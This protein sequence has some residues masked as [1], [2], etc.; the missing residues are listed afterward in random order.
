MHSAAHIY[1][2]KFFKNLWYVD[3]NFSENLS[4]FSLFH[5]IIEASE[6]K[7]IVQPVDYKKMIAYL[8]I[9]GLEQFR[10]LTYL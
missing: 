2:T 1:K 3:R 10:M 5:T 4:L 9:K 7:F 6:T 8:T